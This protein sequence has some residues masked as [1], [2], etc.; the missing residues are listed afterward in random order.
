M[1]TIKQIQDAHGKVKSG[2]DFPAY[3]HDLISMGV[4]HYETFVADG[5]TD[6]Y[7]AN[8][9]KIISPANYELLEVATS[10]NE[11]QFKADLKAH[12]ASKTDYMTF[13]NDAAKSGVER[14][15][16]SMDEM[17]CTYF[18]QAGNNILIEM[19]PQ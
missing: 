5:H 18:D 2:A 7:G 15:A 4:T 1:F 3:I 9:Y 14:W 16:V 8:D 10:S 11:G 17:T 13:C 6:F 19:I 12:Q